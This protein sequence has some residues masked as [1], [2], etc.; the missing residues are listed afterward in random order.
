MDNYYEGSKPR[1]YKQIFYDI[2]VPEGFLA[3]GNFK[4]C[5]MIYFYFRRVGKT[6]MLKAFQCSMP[7]REELVG[8]TEW[9]QLKIIC[10]DVNL[11]STHV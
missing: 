11:G 10:I 7:K 3:I 9:V 5:H 4:T 8:E 6:P 1:T 2:L